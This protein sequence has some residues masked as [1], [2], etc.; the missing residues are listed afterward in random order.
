MKIALLTPSL[1]DINNNPSDNI[2]DIIIYKYVN[3][4]L[5]NLFPEST[6]TCFQT[7]DYLS[8]EQINQI[9][10]SDLRIIGGSNLLSANISAYNQWK[11]SSNKFRY[12]IPELKDIVLLGVGWWQYQD[13]ISYLTKHFYNTVFSKSFIHSV[14]DSYTLKKLNHLGLPNSLNTSCPTT[15]NLDGFKVNFEKKNDKVLFA[16]TDYNK[17]QNSD[18]ELTQVLL[19]YYP[20]LIYFPQGKDDL[21]YLINLEIFK[22]NKPKFYMLPRNID[23]LDSFIINEKFDY[24]GTR[25]HLGIHCLNHYKNSIIIAIDNR[26]QEISNDINLLSVS[27]NNQAEIHSIFSQKLLIPN[28]RLPLQAINSWKQQFLSK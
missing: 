23:D 7:H 18:T 9:K 26:T 20:K 19:D 27:R 25:L 14:R 3:K 17:N 24:I 5:T 4:I 11:Y 28:I 6:I 12:I 16:L 22:K 13:N 21:E 8:S 1:S 15:W 2:G 10:K